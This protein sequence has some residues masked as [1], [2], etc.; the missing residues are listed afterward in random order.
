MNGENGS[1]NSDPQL[2]NDTEV[3]EA[4]NKTRDIANNLILILPKGCSMLYDYL[5]P[6]NYELLKNDNITSY[7]SKIDADLFLNTSNRGSEQYNIYLKK[8]VEHAKSVL[9]DGDSICIT[10]TKVNAAL[11][12]DVLRVA[13]DID[14]FFA[15][16]TAANGAFCVTV[17]RSGDTYTMNGTYYIADKYDFNLGEKFG[18]LGL[19]SNDTMA[20][21]HVAGLARAYYVHGEKDITDYKF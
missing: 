5:H 21:L 18:Y 3:M 4:Y 15:L 9:K 7:N 2:K 14:W 17:S 10:S 12:T 13:A 6:S 20:K 19:P 1:F 16:G 11:N 8:L